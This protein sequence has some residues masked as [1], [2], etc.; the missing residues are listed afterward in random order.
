MKVRTSLMVMSLTL[1]GLPSANNFSSMRL[2]SASTTVSASVRDRRSHASLIASVYLC[3]K[4]S[5]FA[6]SA[7]SCALRADASAPC[8]SCSALRDFKIVVQGVHERFAELLAT[9]LIAEGRDNG[10]FNLLAFE[11]GVV[12]ATVAIQKG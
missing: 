5:W 6:R 11:C 7:S 4:F 3:R 2:I 1:T 10:L 8:S 12:I 9:E